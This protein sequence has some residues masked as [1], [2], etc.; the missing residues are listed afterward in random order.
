M[1]W[2]LSA[3]ATILVVPISSRTSSVAPSDAIRGIDPRVVRG[4]AHRG[5]RPCTCRDTGAHD[6]TTV[7]RCTLH[8]NARTRSPLREEEE[9]QVSCATPAATATPDATCRRPLTM[10]ARSPLFD[11]GG[12]ARPP[13][14]PSEGSADME[15]APTARIVSGLRIHG[16]SWLLECVVLCCAFAAAFFVRYGGQIPAG[17]TGRR[18]L[19]SSALIVGAYT[20]SLLFYRSYRI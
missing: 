7:I 1:G 6:Q 19:L 16:P 17:Y 2:S 12:P 10:I 5:S 14:E 3:L 8:C 13:A 4:L 9:P 20:V 18:A 11:A 15:R